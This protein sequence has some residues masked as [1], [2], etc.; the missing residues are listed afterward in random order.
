MRNIFQQITAGTYSFTA[1]TV[2]SVRMTDRNYLYKASFAPAPPPAT[3]WEGHLQAFTINND[4]TLSPQ[5]GMR[6]KSSRRA[7]RIQARN[8]YTGYTTIT[9]PG[10]AR[11]S[12]RQQHYRLQCS[13]ST[14]RRPEQRGELHPWRQTTTTPSSATSSTPS[15]SSS[16]PPPGSTSTKGIRRLWAG[17]VQSFVDNKQHRKRVVY[18]G[19]NDGMLHAFLS[20]TYDPV[21]GQN[22]ETTPGR[23]RNCGGTF[24]TTFWTTWG[25]SCRRI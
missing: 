1:P 12:T 4:K 24:R 18:V 20:G 7:P 8:I 13:G 16:A 10:P 6:P 17:S 15:R 22:I 19:T 5:F 11:T 3:F 25:I 21:S 14:T 23:A 9:S 2:A